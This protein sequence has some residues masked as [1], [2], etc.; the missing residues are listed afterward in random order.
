MNHFA[1]HPRSVFEGWYSK[2]T[3]PSGASI[4]LVICTVPDAPTRPHMVSFTYVPQDVSRIYQKELWVESIE[5]VELQDGAFELSVPGV[6]YMRCDADSTTTYELVT[7]EFELRG[8]C[9]GNGNRIPW[10]ASQ[11]T[12]EGLLV[13]LPLPL[14][15]HVHSLGSLVDFNLSLPTRPELL[16][17]ADKRGTALLHQEKNWAN[18]FPN[19]HIW[20]QARKE[21]SGFCC[22]GGQILG[23]EAYLIGYR[24]ANNAH[25]LDFKPPLALRMLGFSP[26]MTV[27]VDWETREVRL[28]VQGFWQ[29][30]VLRARAPKGTFF[31]LSSPFPEGHRENFLGQSFQATLEIEVWKR[32]GWLG[33]WGLVHTER[34]EGASLEFGGAYYGSAGTDKKRN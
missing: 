31:P 17:D 29:K 24:A 3:L 7:P 19:A 5:R 33:G 10:S 11:S 22:A 16:F 34:F 21:A 9:R 4:A 14:H 2:F 18:S 28:S 26:F 20:I 8:T 13:Y 15:W 30:L 12:P 1:P 32:R 27:D 6:G 25:S 23:M